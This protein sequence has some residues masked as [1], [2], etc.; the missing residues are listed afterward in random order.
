LSD[1]PSS[2]ETAVRM[3]R[4]RKGKGMPEWRSRGNW[5]T[6]APRSRGAAFQNRLDDGS[7]KVV[8]VWAKDP[9]RAVVAKLSK[10]Q[11]E[12]PK[13]P[14]VNESVERTGPSRFD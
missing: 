11:Q 13:I 12:R 14:G 9:V 10:A 2:L 4:E 7:A 3:I 8:W 6:W 1:S 5:Q